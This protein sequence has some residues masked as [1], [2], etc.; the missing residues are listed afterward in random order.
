MSALLVCLPFLFVM[1]NH[2]LVRGI[3]N[4]ARDMEAKKLSFVRLIGRHDA[5]FLF[6]MNSLFTFFFNL[7]DFFVQNYAYAINFWY[8]IY[9]YFTFEYIMDSKVISRFFKWFSF[10]SFIAYAGLYCY[11]LTYMANPQP[12]RTYPLYDPNKPPETE[13]V[14]GGEL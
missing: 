1:H 2:F 3:R 5:T 4:Y 14:Q 13:E 7:V 6:V 9:A 8:L 11:T 12:D 10:L